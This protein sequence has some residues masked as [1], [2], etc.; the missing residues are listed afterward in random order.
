MW[1]TFL[2]SSVSL[3]AITPSPMV[4]L[5]SCLK[6]S[7][8]QN[9]PPDRD[10]ARFVCLEKFVKVPL[11]VCEKE[12]QK[13][14]YLTNTEEALKN[15]YYSRPESFNTRNCLDVAKKLHTSLDRDS[16]RLDCMSALESQIESSKNKNCLMIANSFEQLHYKERFKQV[17]QEN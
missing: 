3:G 11:S 9:S 14:E 1:I 13:M 10:N 5:Q 7:L 2:V 4:L 15:C 12:A 16:M 8:R 17:C 6:Q